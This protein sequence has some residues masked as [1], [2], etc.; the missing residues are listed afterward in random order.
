[1]NDSFELP[2]MYKGEELMFPAQLVQLGYLHQFKV[3]VFGEEV[4]FEPDE[5]RNYRAIIDPAKLNKKITMELIR[6]MAETI[7]EIVS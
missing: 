3:D 4:I 6:A 1:M 5:E 7:Q 2:V